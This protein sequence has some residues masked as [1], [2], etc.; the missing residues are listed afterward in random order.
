MREIILKSLTGVGQ[1]LTMCLWRDGGTPETHLVPPFCRRHSVT[2]M[3]KHFLSFH[4]LF[5]R[6]RGRRRRKLVSGRDGNLHANLRRSAY[7]ASTFCD[8]EYKGECL[9]R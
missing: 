3:T 7:P 6:A 8:S 1:S 4:L 9:C 5:R 2:V